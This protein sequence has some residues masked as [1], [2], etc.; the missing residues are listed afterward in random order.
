MDFI[1]S[2]FGNKMKRER[3]MASLLNLWAGIGAIDII[4]WREHQKLLMHCLR[5]MLPD[6]D[7]SK[8][9]ELRTMF[10]ITPRAL[11]IFESFYE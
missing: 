5:G 11:T 9:D 10:D 8:A 2:A 4:T 3:V 7:N 6:S 1:L